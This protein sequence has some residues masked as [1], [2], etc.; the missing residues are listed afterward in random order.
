MNGISFLIFT[1]LIVG[2]CLLFNVSPFELT[3]RLMDRIVNDKS[4]IQSVIKKTVRKDRRTPF[5]G[6]T[7]TIREAQLILKTTNRESVFTILV[8]AATI[9]FI[10]GLI[11][12][13]MMENILLSAVL[14]VGLALFPFW[15][16]KLAEI[17]YRKELNDE[18]NK[19]LS[20]ITTSYSRSH[21]I[22]KAIE[23]NLHH[24]NPPLLPV[25]EAF[26]FDISYITADIP[27][28]LLEMSEKIDNQIYK[29]WCRA[30]IACQDNPNLIETLPAIVRKFTDIKEAN[31]DF[32]TDMH[33]PLRIVLTMVFINVGVPVLFYFINKD[34]YRGLMY[35]W[36]GKII[37][38]VVLTMVFISIN[39][40]IKDIKPIEYS[41]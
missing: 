27:G 21:N 14:G 31:D 10:V 4:D 33:T 12:G 2:L 22:V 1:L 8:M 17:T 36:G 15:Y 25:F 13:L 26:V 16:I 23:E 28:A 39:A 19:T 38:A 37:L 40:A 24:I 3:S 6:L 41:R 5:Q 20:I 34:W 18:L 9:L 35:S 7:T 11:L 32:G 30:V 29:E